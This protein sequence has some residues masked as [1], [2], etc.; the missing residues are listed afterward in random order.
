M[1]VNSDTR[2]DVTIAPHVEKKLL[3]NTRIYLLDLSSLAISWGDLYWGGSILEYTWGE[4]Q[5]AIL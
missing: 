2:M 1:C 3:S 5:Y 4:K